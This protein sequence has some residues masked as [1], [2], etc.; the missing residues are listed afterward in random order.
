MAEK[1][2]NVSTHRLLIGFS[3]I[4]LLLIVFGV[5]SLIE[6]RA[7][8]KVTRSIYNHP[9]IVSN[10]SLRATVSIIKMHGSMKDVVFFDLPSE[11]NIA[12][13]AVNEQERVVFESLDTVKKNI[14]GDEGQKLENETRHLFVN[15]K[16][17]R[18]E[19]IKLV[20][21]GQKKKAA[22]I[23]MEKEADYVAK[24]ENKILELTSYARNKATGFMLYGEKINSRAMKTT[25]ILISI[26]L[27]LSVF[28]AFITIRRTQTAEEALRESGEKF[29]LTFDESPIGA[30]I[31]S[32]GFTFQHVNAEL[33]RITGY[34]EQELLKSSITKIV[35][36]DDTAEDMEKGH[37][38][39]SGEIDQ[40]DH[41]ERSIRK[42]G[43][44]IWI[45]LSVR[46]VRDA[47]GKS[48]YFLSLIQDITE[49]KQAEKE[50]QE[51]EERL[52]FVMEGSQL[53]FW[54]WNIETGEVQRNER[55]A[56][57]LGYSIQE[58]ELN[59]KQW[60]D[61]IHTDER[62]VAWKS[63]QD[64]L[65]GR[66]PVHEVEYRILCKDGK[67]KWILDQAMVVKHDQ[68]GRPLRMSGTHS[69]ITE[70]KQA[71]DAL[72]ESEEKYRLLVNNLPGIVFKGFKDWS[73]EFYD[74]GVEGLTGYNMHQFNSGKKKWID[75]IVKEEVESAK[76]TF[77][78][79][80]KT[81]KSYVRNYR[82]A[83][84]DGNIVW[85]QERGFIVCNQDGDIEYVSGVFYDITDRK[86]AE[87]DKEKL[88]EQLVQAQ[89][90]ESIGTLT[91][92]IAH[93]FNNILGIILGNTELAMDDVPEWNPTKVYLKEV[94][95]ASLRAKD[96]VHQL[97]SFARKTTLE[98]KPTNI[99]PI[100]KETLTWLR[101]SIPSSIEIRPNM[102][103]DVDT[104]IAD[105][106]QIAQVLINFS[107]NASHAMPDGGILEVSLKNVE[108]NK[109]TA[110]QYPDLGPGRYV[111]LTVS[112]TGHGIS[113]E[114]ID[115]IFDPYFTTKEI[116]KGTGLGLSV[117]HGIVK[118]HGGAI[119][120]DSE[121]GRGTIFHIYFPVIE[122][123]AAIEIE[124]VEELP[125]GNERILLVDDEESLVYIGRNRLEQLGYQV[126]TRMNPLEA[127]ELFRSKPDQFDLIIMDMTMPEMTG[128]KLTGE[129][130]NI[131]PD[132]PLILCTG[133]S[134]KINGKKAKEI[135]AAGYLDKPHDKRELAKKVR[136]VLD[137][138]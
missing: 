32:L 71:E 33:S 92:G 26:M 35:H 111:N 136:Q 39:M 122:E 25:I 22:K 124:T 12:I 86:K 110:V 60:T 69:D 108:L 37:L 138:E 49:R 130:L 8:S 84:R 74:N 50:L 70:R 73:V 17:V 104:I 75:L 59:V 105:P 87:E 65:E 29:R 30:A 27:L 78:K 119:S 13:N 38:I 129:I 9:L 66:T 28:V 132:I 55:W 51:S 135:G 116:G 134:E 58:V 42:D 20:R 88:E 10:D 11:I 23:T 77:I 21:E 128:D 1:S 137:G 36:P 57:M 93:D 118:S 113:Q 40:F 79:A 61:L 117:V 94:R 100:I 82:L 63:I 18:E 106:T 125:T 47:V 68:Q 126:E 101:S 95:T 6:I 91:G 52:T 24:L 103:K 46:V 127:L 107:T 16:P 121:L 62:A 115:R 109:D 64:H 98:K 31:V 112:D 4:I 44:V 3:F 15:W 133:F 123:A 102:T 89:K 45:R 83:I 34:S 14:L 41:E 120:V 43:Q 114:E 90:M 96:V 53:G 72:K 2:R 85:I 5:I 99:I 19:V 81:D 67:Y 131:R 7:L 80:L 54:D 76:Q 48:L 56:G 97:L